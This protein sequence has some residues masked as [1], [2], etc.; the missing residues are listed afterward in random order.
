[1]ASGPG[2][3]RRLPRC[4][5]F[6]VF[7]DPVPLFIPSAEDMHSQCRPKRRYRQSHFVRAK[8][9]FGHRVAITTWCRR[10]V[11]PRVAILRPDRYTS[12]P[13]A[14]RMRYGYTNMR[15]LTI[16]GDHVVVAERHV[17]EP[18][19]DQ[20]VVEVAGAGINRGDLLQV[21]GR[22]PPPPGVPADIPGL[23]FAGTVRGAGPL[24]RSLRPGDQVFGIVGGG[25]QAD[26]P[27]MTMAKTVVQPAPGCEANERYSA[28]GSS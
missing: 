25:A 19:A 21:A 15:A 26:T 22:Y 12:W 14:W 1:M 11:P 23:E 3:A 4:H 27:A 8:P 2:S 20:L 24:V 10:V 5:P 7:R 13:R 18:V 28:M 17:D 6:R 9:G 16:V